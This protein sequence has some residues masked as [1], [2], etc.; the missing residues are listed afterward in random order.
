LRE[1]F[2]NIKRTVMPLEAIKLL[3]L[4]YKH[5]WRR[6]ISLLLKLKALKQMT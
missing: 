2:Q 3:F 4:I 6:C 1:I 5:Y